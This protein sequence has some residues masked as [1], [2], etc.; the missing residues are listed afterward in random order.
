MVLSIYLNSKYQRKSQGPPT[1]SKTHPL[2]E[3]AIFTL[4]SPWNG[5][6][7]NGASTYHTS[8]ASSNTLFNEVSKLSSAVSPLVNVE[9]TTSML[10]TLKV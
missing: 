2:F 8:S 10:L 6:L 7:G 1:L 3:T 9:L 5:K 4:P